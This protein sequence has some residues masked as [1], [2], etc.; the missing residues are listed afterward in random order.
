M[1][2]GLHVKGKA[3]P[4]QALTSPKGSRRL[5]FQDFKTIGTWRLSALSTGRLYPQEIFLVSISVRGWVNPRAIVRP[6]GLC[7]WKI[8]MTPSGIDPAIF[9][10]VAQCL[11]HSATA[12]PP[13]R[14]VPGFIVRL[15]WNVNFIDRF[16]KSTQIARVIKI[17]PVGAELFHADRRT[18]IAKLMV[19]FRNFFRARLTTVPLKLV[20]YK[21]SPIVAKHDTTQRSGNYRWIQKSLYTWWLQYKKTHKN[22]LNS[23]N[24]L[25]W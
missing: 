19:A 17:R 11:N 15:G 14:E 18:D 10:F 7:Q 1:Y 12:C 22:I 20:I 3:I 8:P 5:R 13:S 25:P 9:R 16:S 4:L 6:K 2:V 21:T 24:H 23:L